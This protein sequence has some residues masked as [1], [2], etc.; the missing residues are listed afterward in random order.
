MTA[1][2]QLEYTSQPTHLAHEAQLQVVL[3]LAPNVHLVAVNVVL[4]EGPLLAAQ[5]NA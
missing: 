3:A 1:I 2:I 5:Q 4:R